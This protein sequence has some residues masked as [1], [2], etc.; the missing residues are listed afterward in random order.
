M[1]GRFTLT[2]NLK[3]IVE[4]F[5]VEEHGIEAHLPRYNIAPSQEVPVILMEEEQRKLVSMRWGL[6]PR[7][8]KDPSIG[9]RLINA[10]S[11][12]LT[13]KP[14]FRRSFQRYRCLVPADSFYEWKKV[15][16]TKQPMRIMFTS[17]ELFAFAGLW[18][19]WTEESGESYQSFTII[20]TQA[21]EMVQEIHERMP[22]IL[23]LAEE[24]AWLDPDWGDPDL[25]SPFLEP[26]EPEAM[27]MY[28]V[29]KAVN[30]P[31]NDQAE[32][33][34]SLNDIQAG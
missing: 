31:K 9:N 4:R 18:D 34:R 25:L 24:A 1:C 7:W 30:T 5:Q 10:R 19:C 27:T 32:V 26:Y 12:S 16:G 13:Q 6:I 14:A 29:S 2:A 20:T 33:I 22:V 3:E 8:A 21:N 17:G 28:P 11:E 23:H 15:D